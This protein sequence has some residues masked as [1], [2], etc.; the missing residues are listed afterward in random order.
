MYCRDVPI[1][2]YIATA[3]IVASSPLKCQY[4]LKE[5][6][7][8]LT[9]SDKG[10]RIVSELRVTFQQSH[11]SNDQCGQFSVLLPVRYR[12]AVS[13]ITLTVTARRFLFFCFFLG[14]EL[15]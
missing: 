14:A 3:R 4:K 7:A 15:C 1:S 6:H 13:Q 12:C 10:E 9:G 2:R 11:L 5:P 8:A